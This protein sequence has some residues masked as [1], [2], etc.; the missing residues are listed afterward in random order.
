[1]GRLVLGGGAEDLK[2]GGDDVLGLV[3]AP[4][5][6]EGVGEP[7][8]AGDDVEGVAS[9][10]GGGDRSVGGDPAASGSSWRA[11]ATATAW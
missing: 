5:A 1:M 11:K 6:D 2:R 3:E 8:V 9:E 4:Q 10:L 7:E